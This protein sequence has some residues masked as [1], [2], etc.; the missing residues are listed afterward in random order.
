MS[1]PPLLRR[2]E[3]TFAATRFTVPG[4]R[5]AGC[6]AKIE[7]ELPK[8]PG[9]H[10][11]RANFS[12]K[13][14]AIEHDPGLDEAVLE[15]A[16]LALGFEAQAVADNPL[17]DDAKERKS[18]TRALGVA[19]FGMMN[20]MLL[21]VSIWSG[22]D[23]ATK[24]LF[25][26]LSALIA[27]PVIAYSGRPFFASAW[28]AL[29]HRRTNM[30][31]PISIGVML[32][33]ALSIYET[34]TGGD[35]AYFESAVM[36][37]F[38]LLAGRALDA[39]MRTRTR[40]GI[41][42]LLGR[43][44]KSA[45]VISP[46]GTIRRVAAEALSPGML[47]LVAAG[48]ALA[49]DGVIE[50]GSSTIDNAMLTGE[51]APEAVLPGST[52]HA[53]TINLAAPLQVRL[54]HVAEDTALAE[55]A[56]LMDEAGQSRSTYVRIADRASRLYAPVVHT[57]AALAFVG[58]MI[59]GAGWHQS[60]VIAI[61]VLIITC[62]CAM[63]LA[64]PSAQVVASGALLRRGLL[65]KDGSA[66]E[67]LAECDVAL[68]DKTGTLTLGEPRPDITALD[69]EARSVA[70]GLAQASRH[71]LSKG[72]AASL[73]REGVKP[74][75]ITNITEV[76][77]EG[78]S[79]TWQ[80]LRVAL[81]RPQS[82][83]SALATRLTIGETSQ[84]ITFAD[85]LRSDAADTLRALGEWQIGAQI[86]S[87]DRAAPV[88]EVAARLGLVATAEASPQAKLAALE[89]LRAEG[90]RPL[91]VGDGLNDGPA[92]AAAHASIAPGTASDASQQAA[93]A[94]FIGEKLMPV[95]LAIRVAKATMR[96][97]RENFAFSIAYNVLAVPLALFGL[98]TPL[99]AA[100]AMSLSSLV[101]VAN[102][103]RL[104]RSAK[105]PAR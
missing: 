72:L 4:M 31:V 13:R 55:I 90:R 44:G 98:V 88:A 20:I 17:G 75:A 37:L 32:A 63:G 42:A 84:I 1:P 68:F 89:A 30:D 59:A 36:L 35:H 24:Q 11:A 26:W 27:L 41:G 58:W 94:V 73:L 28:M 23:G 97:V 12:A 50:Q 85:P 70:L 101:V 95:A 62:P 7:R 92:L 103:L 80:G 22:A 14:V 105:E 49:A 87:G 96:I 3:R 8:T 51:S 86:L 83:S 69:S 93:D 48:E 79:G 81:E 104:A 56:R 78:L 100:I 43:M 53:G 38:F 74:A 46:D 29:S 21:S 19:G 71:P 61:A 82:A 9:I 57:L 25:H 76:S 60:L 40:A 5:C 77:G 67:R 2:P 99:I 10:A 54:T 66:L 39:E 18:L 47:V 64:V 52:V 34:I 45:S 16:L 65:V 15:R 6:I 102:S 33:T 91:M